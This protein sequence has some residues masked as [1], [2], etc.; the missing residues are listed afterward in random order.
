MSASDIEVAAAKFTKVFGP[1]NN[2]RAQGAAVVA[3]AAKVLYEDALGEEEGS[4]IEAHC[5]STEKGGW[6]AHL[7]ESRDAPILLAFLNDLVGVAGYTLPAPFSM[8]PLKRD[9]GCICMKDG[10][11]ALAPHAEGFR[12]AAK[13]LAGFER[14]WHVP[15][16]K[17][18]LVQAPEFGEVVKQKRVVLYVADDAEGVKRRKTKITGVI[19]LFT[20]KLPE[21]VPA[22]VKLALTDPPPQLPI[23][24]AGGQADLAGG[25]EGEEEGEEALG[26]LLGRLGW[27]MAG[28]M[29]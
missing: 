9:G 14:L 15:G 21:A 18:Y 8:S 29:C 13:T 3:V 26:R 24:Q 11:E 1:K 27:P 23:G 4:L 22:K 6:A 25:S 19:L 28:R 10:K 17:E 7:C 2:R 20:G 5:F 12:D 16:L